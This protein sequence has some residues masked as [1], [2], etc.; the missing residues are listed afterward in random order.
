MFHS[1]ASEKSELVQ[2]ANM[3]EVI[4]LVASIVAV[5][6]II[7]S[8]DKTV[9]KYLTTLKS[10][11][12][13]LIPLLSRLRHLG[14]IMSTLQLSLETVES[15]FL[16]VLHDPL[17]ICE[18]VLVRIDWRLNRL[19]V[20]AGCVV[21]PL[22]DKESL[23][24]LK[25]LDDL[26]PV[27]QLALDAEQIASTHAL[28]EYLQSLRLE[29]REQIQVLQRDVRALHQDVRNLAE[30]ADHSKVKAEVL[31]WLAPI[32]PELNYMAARQKVQA[33]TGQWLWETKEFLE[34][35]TGD[36]KGIWLNAMGIHHLDSFQNYRLI[37]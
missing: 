9:S 28:E 17:R 24:C 23:E 33:G 35:E 15:P 34:W 16:Q 1:G 5:V 7:E 19:K 30:E 20:I 8:V 18:E 22:L 11:R 3:A 27:L 36:T 37:D 32:N 10:V 25:Q 21:G 29:N 13:E 12:S 2:L 31:G 4:G 26:T 6:Q 14:Y